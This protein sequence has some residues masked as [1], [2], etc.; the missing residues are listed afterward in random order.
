AEDNTRIIDV[1]TS[2]QHLKFLYLTHD[3]R[4]EHTE[5]LKPI[6]HD[7]LGKRQTPLLCDLYIQDDHPYG[8]QSLLGVSGMRSVK[9]SFVNLKYFEDHP[10]KPSGMDLTWIEWM[11]EYLGVRRNLRLHSR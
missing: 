7:H 6:I 3:S 5:I 11:Y 9:A 4:S 8:A 10:R 1:N 2:Q